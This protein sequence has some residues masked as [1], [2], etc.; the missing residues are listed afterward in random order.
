MFHLCKHL[1]MLG[2]KCRTESPENDTLKAAFVEHINSYGQSYAT[3]EEFQF[4]FEIF[5]EN[6]MKIREINAEEK[7]FQVGHN[8]FSTLTKDEFKRVRGRFQR[9]IPDT[10]N[11]KHL[12]ELNL[13]DSID[14]RAKGAV[15]PIQDQGGCGSCWAFSAV[16]TMESDHFIQKGELLK[17]SEQQLVDCAGIVK[18]EGC[19]GCYDYLAYQYAEQV[20]LQ[21]EKDY[22]YTGQDDDCKADGSKSILGVESY[23][24]LP[25]KSV[26]QMKA[27][28]A[29][30]P[31]AISV[32][33]S[34]DRFQFYRKGIMD[35][36]ECGTLVDHAVTAVGYGVENGQEYLIVRNSWSI[37]WGDQGYIRI[38]IDKDG[39]GI[40]GCLMTG[41]YPK[42]K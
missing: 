28:V 13:P 25:P 12:D 1:G 38:A 42:T 36:Q 40:C 21:S 15:Q 8:H 16:A 31:V 29:L 35:S 9:D 14:W 23:V 22:G 4:R 39:E 24:T 37:W 19:K 7:N 3:K 30:Q 32:D 41:V 5:K 17:L 10:A 33:G 26:S 27:A 11:V 18:C 2:L 20:G 6:D 34:S